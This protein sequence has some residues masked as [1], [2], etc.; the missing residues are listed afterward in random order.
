MDVCAQ[1]DLGLYTGCALM[2]G[3]AMPPSLFW[4]VNIWQSRAFWLQA[5]GQSNVYP[6]G[7][8]FP[9]GKGDDSLLSM[10]VKVGDVLIGRDIRQPVTIEH[11][12]LNK[13]EHPI[14][15]DTK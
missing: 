14:D 3:C 13:I 4:N 2:H 12:N 6:L 10:R 7:R 1:A 11:G 15:H 5:Q 9:G 8:L